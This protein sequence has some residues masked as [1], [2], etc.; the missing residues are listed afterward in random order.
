[1]ASPGKKYRI[2]MLLENH[3]YPQDTR[4]RKEALALVDNGYE[5][6]VICPRSKQQAWREVINGVYVMR[7]AEPPSG[8][9]FVNFVAEYAY[10]L[11][12]MFLFTLQLAFGRGFD[13]IHAHNPPDFSV[14]VALPF[15][16]FGKKFIFDHHDVSPEQYRARFGKDASNFV[17]N[18]LLFFEKLTFWA[19]DHVISTNESY[20]SIAMRRGGK[21][22][23]QVT[24]V[25]NGPEDSFAPVEP[26]AALRA[27]GKIILGY[28]GVMG[29]QDGIDYFVRAAKHLHDTLK[30]DDFYAVMIGKGD[31]LDSLREL[32]TSLQ[33]DDYIWWTG[34]VTDEEVKRYLSSTDICVAPDPFNPFNDPSTMIKVTEYMA[35]GKPVVAFNLTEHRATAAEAAVYVDNNDELEFAK[36]IAALMDDP[37]RRAQMGAIGRKRIDDSLA[38]KYQYQNLLDAYAKGVRKHIR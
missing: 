36:A 27:K 6:T 9:G 7:Y 19:A 23:D 11:V 37:A 35:M 24:V 13:A 16:L 1:M 20:R 8:N 10:S 2:C 38:W 5:V 18:V 30:R 3:P 31:A 33:L 32:T 21:R 14:L 29:F 12:M 28:I 25:R 26:D 15:K 34:R 4:V 22:P 17:Y